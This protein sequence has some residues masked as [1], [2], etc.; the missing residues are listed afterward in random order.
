MESSARK[1][2]LI[3]LAVKKIDSGSRI[4]ASIFLAFLE[5]FGTS[6]ADLAFVF[7]MFGLIAGTWV[8]W[9]RQAMRKT[10]IS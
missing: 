10:D 1:S 9:S 5:N 8:C 3:E 6:A 2:K 4:G 7:V